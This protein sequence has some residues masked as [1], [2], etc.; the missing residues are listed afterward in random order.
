VL[1]GVVAPIVLAVIIAT[2]FGGGRSFSTEIGSS[3]STVA[4]S[5]P[6]WSPERVAPPE[7]DGDERRVR[8]RAA[9]VRDRAAAARRS[10]RGP[11]GG[12][13][14]PRGLRRIARA[15]SHDRSANRTPS[16][17]VLVDPGR[18][19]PSDVALSIATRFAAN[20]ESTRLAATTA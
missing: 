14:D 19:L 17:E 4:S 18:Q 7:D 10:T 9:R 5:A 16:P 15:R 1:Q 20:V 11:A 2:A 13:R 6:R 12:D 3:T 8:G